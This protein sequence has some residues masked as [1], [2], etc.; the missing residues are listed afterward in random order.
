MW[1]LYC[2]DDGN[3]P[4]IWE[5]WFFDDPLVSN[6][7]RARHK[8]VWKYLEGMQYWTDYNLF[9]DSPVGGV[10]EV[11][12]LVKKDLQ[13]RLGGVFGHREFTVLGAFY[14]KGNQYLPKAILNEIET[15]KDLLK[16]ANFTKRIRREP[17]EITDRAKVASR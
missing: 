9:H 6:A 7:I 2:Y 16:A 13:W 12:I 1:T 4:D 15:R 17:P 10:K 3:K 11:R 14:H 8:V 5:R